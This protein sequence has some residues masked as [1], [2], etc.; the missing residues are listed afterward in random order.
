VKADGVESQSWRCGR[1]Q[2]PALA[3]MCWACGP[4]GQGAP[5][6]GAGLLGGSN[7]AWGVELCL[8][9]GVWQLPFEDHS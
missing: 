1:Y 2:T 9:W 7:Q 6:W 8:L 5:G 4:P 3:G